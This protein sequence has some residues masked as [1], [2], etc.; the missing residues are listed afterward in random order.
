MF[1]GHGF[2]GSGFMWLFWILIIAA[3]FLLTKGM[4]GSRNN[5]TSS[6]NHMDILRK[7]LA[8]GEITSDE[9]ESLSKDLEK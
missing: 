6:E 7:R 4:P 3:I 9:F 2:F 5:A 1:D 8:S